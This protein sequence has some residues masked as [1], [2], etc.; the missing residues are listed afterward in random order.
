MNVRNVLNC[1]RLCGL[2][3]DSG[4]ENCEFSAPGP[5]FSLQ[6]HP[7]TAV[8]NNGRIDE[9]FVGVNSGGR[10]FPASAKG[11]TGR[12]FRLQPGRTHPVLPQEVSRSRAPVDFDPIHARDPI[13]TFELAR[14]DDKV[15]N[16]GERRLVQANR[17]KAEDLRSC[18]GGPA[19]E[20][21]PCACIRSRDVGRLGGGVRNIPKTAA[22]TLRS[23]GFGVR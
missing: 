9:I 4:A 8:R 5:R 15:K 7:R 10:Q 14:V 18:I 2:R 19:N 6:N 23:S 20:D 22:G 13:A 1:E 17:I 21:W 11:G 12:T 16:V 3:P